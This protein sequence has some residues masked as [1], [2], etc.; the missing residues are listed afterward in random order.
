MG[1]PRQTQSTGYQVFSSLLSAESGID[2]GTV[3]STLVVTLQ[4]NVAISEANQKEAP[5]MA[6]VNIYREIL[7]WSVDRPEWQRDALRR[8]VTQGS[9]DDSDINELVSLCKSSHGLNEKIES[10]PLS[11]CHL[12]SQSQDGQAV[13][14]NSL[15]HHA[16]VNALAPDQTITFGPNLTVVYGDN[17]AGKSGYTRILKR[18]CRARDIA[19]NILGNVTSGEPPKRPSATINYSVGNDSIDY[20]WDEDSE[21]STLSRVSVFDS[22]CAGV[23]IT[24]RM[25]VAFRPM[26]LDLFDHLAQTCK[27]VK[28]VLDKE[29]MVLENQEPHLPT[30]PEG[31]AVHD[32]LDNLTAHTSTD[33]VKSLAGVNDEEDARITKLQEL[34][35]NLTDD[36]PLALAKELRLRA[37]RVRALLEKL[38]ECQGKLSGDSVLSLFECRRVHYDNKATHQSHSADLSSM[39]LPNIGSDSWHRLWEGAREFSSNDAYPETSFPNVGEDARC[40]LCQQPL[41]S[42][43][44]QHMK[45]LRDHLASAIERDYKQAK[46]DLD[47]ALSSVKSAEIDDNSYTNTLDEIALDQPDIAD[48]SRAC[49]RT[50][51]ERRSTILRAVEEDD[52]PPISMPAL[53]LSTLQGYI[54]NLVTRSEEI[55]AYTTTENINALRRELTELESRKILGDSIDVVLNEIDRKERIEKYEK[56]SSETNTTTITRKSSEVTKKVV[57]ER[58]VESFTQELNHLNFHKIGVEFKEDGGSHGSLYHKLAL[59]QAPNEK[60]SKVV[61][62][63]EARCLSMAAFL[64]ELSTAEDRSAILFDDPV[65][66]LDHNCRHNVAERLVDEAR[67]RQ[68]IVFTH[69]LVFWHALSQE[70]TRRGINNHEQFIQRT[71]T[72]VGVLSE[73]VSTPAMTVNRRFRHLNDRLQAIKSLHQKGNQREYEKEGSDTYGFLRDTWERGVEEVLLAG[74][75][76]RY[77]PDV[78][79]KNKILKLADISDTD[80]ESVQTAMSKCSKHMC[81]HATPA[82]DNQPFPGPEEIEQDIGAFDAW[83]KSIKKRRN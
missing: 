64:S 28:E 14:L 79:T 25:E 35:A 44:R 81:G 62:E 5:Q 63:G 41:S 54:D 10:Q 40:V 60:M 8:L 17:G 15:K 33:D 55:K 37:D 47:V 23:Y 59:T 32:L 27:K 83:V 26:G 21:G 66:S 73:N 20:N 56:C 77:R 45:R 24:E 6:S 74:V 3:H 2:D 31:T 51:T 12:P 61:S 38:E 9:I 76:E 67:I 68:V 16:G 30:V 4:S 72:E 22:H 42:E 58:L 52:S 36:N 18:A 48:I 43:G 49:M 46:C 65:S 71:A 78:Q 75:V 29:R 82:A 70:A 53:D 34:I 19:E 80:C 57:T 1:L 11:A 50:L 39:P 13:T 69:D 7:D